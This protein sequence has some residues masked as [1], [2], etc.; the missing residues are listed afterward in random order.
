MEW[1]AT[2]LRNCYSFTLI[3][4]VVM[5]RRMKRLITRNAAEAVC[6]GLI[7]QRGVV[8]M[9]IQIRYS[10][11]FEMLTMFFN[12]DW[13]VFHA[14]LLWC[15]GTARSESSPYGRKSGRF[16]RAARLPDELLRQPCAKKTIFRDFAARQ[17]LHAKGHPWWLWTYSRPRSP[18]RHPWS[19]R[20][21]TNRTAES[22]R[23]W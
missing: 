23:S 2:R 6:W 22:C 15:R 13:I 20:S 7:A 16:D 19:S 8:I 1:L 9:R 5:L 3:F 10:K 4:I 14:I 12:D 11:T 21:R 17:I 18:S